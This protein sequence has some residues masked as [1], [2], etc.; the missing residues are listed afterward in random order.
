M[1]L[2]NHILVDSSQ[3]APSKVHLKERVRQESLNRMGDGKLESFLRTGQGI[4]LLSKPQEEFQQKNEH[5]TP[6]VTIQ[7]G[8]GCMLMPKANEETKNGNTGTT[9]LNRINAPQYNKLK[10]NAFV[11][12]MII[13]SDSVGWKNTSPRV[14]GIK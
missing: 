7:R 4:M 5:V 14:I 10:I 12:I 13:R 6:R 1:C 8:L 3:T 9:S 11:K 2:R